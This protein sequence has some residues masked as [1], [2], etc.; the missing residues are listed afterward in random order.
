TVCRLKNG[1]V[2]EF[3]SDN[4]FPGRLPCSLAKDNRGRIWFAK[5]NAVGIFRNDRFETLFRLR[6]FNSFLCSARE[7]GMWVCSDFQLFKYEENAEPKRVGMF[8][9]DHPSTGLTTMMEDHNGVVWIGTSDS[10]LFCY[11]DSKVEAVSGV[12]GAIVS[13]L[14][15]REGN[16]WAGTDGGGLG[17]IQPRVIELKGADSGLPFA[18]VQSLSENTNGVVWATTQNGLLVR[19]IDD[20]WEMVSRSA[21]WPGGEATCVATD[22]SGSIWVGTQDRQLHC[23]AGGSWQ[24]W[25]TA[26]GLLSHNIHALLAASDGDLWIA[27]NA[28][29][30]LQRLHSG[31]IVTVTLPADIGMIRAMVEDRQGDIWMGTTKH[32]LLHVHEGRVTDESS[33]IPGYFARSI[34][35]LHFTP[36]GSL[37]I[38][39]AGWGLGRLKEGRFARITMQDGL[40]DDFI[41]QIMDDGHGWLWFGADHGI[42]KVRQQEL[43]MRADG[44]GGRVQSI[45]YGKGQGLP[46]L[47]ANFDNFPGALH[48]RDGRLW[49]PMRSG[50]AIINPDRANED[51]QPA[52]VLMKR[53]L[54]DD[55]VAA[56][57]GGNLPVR[58]GLGLPAA[59]RGL[60]LSPGYHRLK[61]EFTAL[62]FSAPE[63]VRFRYRLEG[64]DDGWIDGNGQ[65]SASYSRV[66]AGN[67][68][69]HV[70]ACNSSGTWG[71]D[72][73]AFAFMVAP[74]LWQTWW[75]RSAA[76]V[77]FTTMV[78][79]LARYISFRRL[80]RTLRELEH[81]A[82]L[83]RERVRIAKD[84]HD[85]LGGRLTEVELMIELANRTPPE[86]RNGQMREISATV[87]QAGESLDEIVWAVNP[88]HDTLPRLLDYLGEYAVQFLQRAG[89]RCRADFPDHPPDQPV[90]P[91]VRHNV[92]LA[93]KEALNNVA[94]HAQAAEI[95]LRVSLDEK[96]MDI[97]I[98]D[99]GKG[100][101]G[102][103]D[104]AGADGLK[105]MH[106]R[107]EDIGGRFHIESQP[108]RGTRIRMTL[109]WPPKTN[110]VPKDT[111]G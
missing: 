11:K 50:L 84:L 30:S 106:Q 69:F 72:E 103:S 76:V 67:Y 35:D 1:I 97:V 19:G 23:L 81:Q 68:R 36:D 42:F 77:V 34:R 70:V 22:R 40:Y 58:D 31:K 99:N 60:R 29:E 74:F 85:D 4:G 53:A 65:R 71:S 45:C 73:V 57:Y 27:G 52:T 15:D 102:G 12:Q 47:Q 93:V 13:L 96:S 43:D 49:L 2:T 91:E 59:S 111:A 87:R 37:W 107:M 64:A 89:I 20:D 48:S 82:A 21:G 95:W 108:G 61:F 14:E 16:I 32:V 101:S 26:E 78:F 104:R 46:N 17:R 5:G 94:R 62:S 98:E 92:F 110:I 28:P 6:G 55:A 88:R 79:V 63:N 25:G 3:T 38:G 18:T 90:P 80:R 54:V 100:F 41:S 86:Q 10:G 51:P 44:Q 75:F 7:G 24:T 109:P 33:T 39:Y 105:N 8:H 66:A 83:A 9:P 56:S